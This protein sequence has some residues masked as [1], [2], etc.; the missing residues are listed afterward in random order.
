MPVSVPTGA[1][2]SE[3]RRT[4][5]HQQDEGDEI[6][7]RSR[8]RERE[9]RHDRPGR[10]RRR[11]EDERRA[12]QARRFGAPLATPRRA[13]SSL[14]CAA[15][16]GS[17]ATASDSGRPADSEDRRVPD[18]AGKHHAKRQ[19][20]HCRHTRHNPGEREPLTAPFG[21]YERCGQRATGYDRDTEAE[22]S[23]QAHRHDQRRARRHHQSE[24]RRPEE[25]QACRED[26]CDI[27]IVAA[28]HGVVSSPAT[29]RQHQ[30][31]GRPSRHSARPRRGCSQRD[32]REQQVEADRRCRRSR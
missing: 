25:Q 19:C 4:G 29:L 6:P 31:A 20:H 28:T 30:G 26:A 18:G 14:R 5:L 7:R 22:S 12:N 8:D 9:E 24:S 32:N 17:A 10:H 23:Y 3:R 2:S 27:Q 15:A 21:R 1:Y 16:R 11:H 13:S